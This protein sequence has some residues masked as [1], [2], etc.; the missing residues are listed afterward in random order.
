MSKKKLFYTIFIA[1]EGNNTEPNYLGRLVEE[2]DEVRRMRV[3]I[4]PR[5]KI[6]DADGSALPEGNRRSDPV[7]LVEACRAQLDTF[8]EAWAVFDKDGHSGIAD[9]FK[10]ANEPVDG[11]RVR[12][13]FSSIAFEHWILLHFEKN[14]TAFLKSA[15]LIAKHFHD[16]GLFPNYAKSKRIDIYPVLKGRTIAALENA[17]WLRYQA[18][19]D[20]EIP[21]GAIFEMNPYTNVDELVK[22]LLDINIDYH[23]TDWGRETD[24]CGFSIAAIKSERFFTVRIKN[25]TKQTL[26]INNVNLKDHFSL[27]NRNDL[28][29]I[30]E[31]VQLAPGAES[32]FQID[33][34]NL[35]QADAGLVFRLGN[36]QLF[37]H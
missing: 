25:N 26:L 34:A 13:A 14:R 12:I 6:Q 9:A 3:E 28:L 24:F 10:L 36:H 1:C 35:F 33:G 22:I 30:L 27:N 23:W 18:R 11:K 4:F 29:S 21:G 8:D 7:G 17:A 37:F 2:I 19:K 16:R 31:T 5:P 20:Q 32:Q 15:D